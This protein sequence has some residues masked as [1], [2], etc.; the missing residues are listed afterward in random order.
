M[1][2]RIALTGAAGFFGRSIAQRLAGSGHA[3]RCW[4]RSAAARNPLHHLDGAI[5]WVE[6]A[7]GKPGG[8]PRFLAGCGAVVHAALG[9]AWQE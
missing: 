5:E 1:T 4:Y 2:M 7:F 6:G 3:L 9:D 8:F